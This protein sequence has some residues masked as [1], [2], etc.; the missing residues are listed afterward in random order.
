[1]LG[2]NFKQMGN[3]SFRFIGYRKYPYFYYFHTFLL[4]IFLN[5]REPVIPFLE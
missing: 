1:M 2:S 5:F 4:V 3:C